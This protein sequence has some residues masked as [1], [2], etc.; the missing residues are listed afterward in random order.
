[1]SRTATGIPATALVASAALLGGCQV[2]LHD[3][4]LEK[5]TAAAVAAYKEADVPGAIKATITAQ[6][7]F[8]EQM[9]SSIVAEDAAVR[10]LEIAELLE[11]G[12]RAVLRALIDDRLKEINVLVPPSAEKDWTDRLVA[13]ELLRTQR[14]SDTRI[15]NLFARLY[16]DAGGEAFRK[17]DQ[18]WLLPAPGGDV[19]L[20][21]AADALKQACNAWL[22]IAES[23]DQKIKGFD[24]LVCKSNPASMLAETCQQIGDTDKRIAVDEDE[25]ETTK[26]NLETAK[27]ALAKA[28]EAGTPEERISEKLEAFKTELVRAD[29]LVAELGATDFK[30]S[31]ALAAIEFRETNLC[32]V[33]LAGVGTSCSGGKVDEKAKKINESV[34][35]LISGLAKVVGPPP[36]TDALS[37]ALS[38][39]SGLQGAVQASLEGRRAQ[40]AL[41]QTWQNALVQ[42]VEYLVQARSWLDIPKEKAEQKERARLITVAC[43]DNSL[44]TAPRAKNCRDRVGLAN[45]LTAYNL[46]W[47]DGRTAARIA[48]ARITMQITMS[49]LRVAQATAASRDSMLTTALAGLDSFG[50]GGVST[51]TI[52]ELLQALGIAAVAYGV[53]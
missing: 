14:A 45:A 30:P 39:Q 25:A 7:K 35:G 8:D 6:E 9:L 1:M 28:V 19:K 15:V 12:D 22:P 51:Q 47:A 46:S 16:R 37:I 50:Q 24:Q 21:A 41:L 49:D 27:K 33:L 3:E 23:L 48:Y 40:R 44:S 4:V 11:S 34:I 5:Q 53:N 42:E 26:R 38:Y 17:C 52:A 2:Y 29:Q 32:D 43:S 10:D 18:N 13:L 20:A 36:Q 31:A